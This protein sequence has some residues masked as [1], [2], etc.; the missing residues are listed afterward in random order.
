MLG[1]K[2]AVGWPWRLGDD[3]V[4]IFD[5]FGLP[6]GALRGSLLRAFG[7]QKLQIARL[8]SLFGDFLVA[9]NKYQNTKNKLIK[10]GTALGG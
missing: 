1:S 5:G 6:L 8:G 2:G 7:R 10:K 9:S 4:T 3:F